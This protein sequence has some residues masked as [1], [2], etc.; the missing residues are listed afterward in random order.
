MKKILFILS[1]SIVLFSCNNN[2]IKVIETI[3]YK[4][5]D[6]VEYH[7]IGSDNTL[8]TTPYWKV[9][10]SGQSTPVR[11]YRKY[12]VGDTIQ[13]IIKVIKEKTK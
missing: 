10:L 13:V 7:P 9:R 8:Q 12:N 6:S 2:N 4:T 5:V 11:V 3:E 1:M